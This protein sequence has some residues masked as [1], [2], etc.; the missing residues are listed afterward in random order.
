MAAAAICDEEPDQGPH[1]VHV[2]S[3]DD[4]APF[5]RSTNQSRASKNADVRRQRVRRASYRLRDRAGREAAGLVVHEEAEHPQPGLLTQGGELR[6]PQGRRDLLDV[7]ET[8][9]V[10]DN[11]RRSL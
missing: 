2:G 11:I 5:A 8:A 4:R 10:A 7:G 6:K 1:A 9:D 3:V